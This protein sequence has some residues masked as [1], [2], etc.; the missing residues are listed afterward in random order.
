MGIELGIINKTN[1]NIKNIIKME[2][3]AQSKM[4]SPG[5]PIEL[6]QH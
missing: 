4:E 1:I 5:S 6:P 2:L 3:P